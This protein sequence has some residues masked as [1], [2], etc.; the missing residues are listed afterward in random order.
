MF[1]K[2]I[3]FNIMCYQIINVTLNYLSFPFNVNLYLTDDQ[4]KEFPSIT[5][6][7][8]IIWQC[9]FNVTTK[10]GF[11]I[12]PKAFSTIIPNDN[13][14]CKVYFK[15]QLKFINCRQIADINQLFITNQALKCFSYFNYY[16]TNNNSFI[17]NNEIELIKIE[18]SESLFRNEQCY[19]GIIG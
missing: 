15:N 11:I 7:F 1:Y 4:N 8:P 2:I 13:L 9:L 19:K 6:C 3:C 16:G 14:D 12:K 10:Y 17:N 5:I 18:F